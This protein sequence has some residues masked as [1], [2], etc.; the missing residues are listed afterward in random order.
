MVATAQ[1]GRFAVD[2]VVRVRMSPTTPSI[3]PRTPPYARGH[4][5]TVI[6]TYGIVANPQDHHL[7][8]EPLYTVRFD[9]SEIWGP[10]ATHVVVAEVHDEWLDRESA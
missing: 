7:P 10:Q 2:D 8:Y 4:V 5:G 3:N 1:A 6:R 9:A